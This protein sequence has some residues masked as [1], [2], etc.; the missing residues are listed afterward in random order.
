MANNNLFITIGNH[1]NWR[2][3]FCLFNKKIWDLCKS[4]SSLYNIN[5]LVF[6]KFGRANIPEKPLIGIKYFNL[7][8]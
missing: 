6:I 7:K 8:F 1:A 5:H 2:D 3:F 4:N